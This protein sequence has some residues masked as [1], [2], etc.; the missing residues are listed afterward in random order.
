MKIYAKII[1]LTE[2]LNIVRINLWQIFQISD[3]CKHF[4]LRTVIG[5]K[6]QKVYMICTICVLLFETGNFANV[7]VQKVKNT[8]NTC[9]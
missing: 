9:V 5:S 3:F 8:G 1:K 4:L 2:L 6:K 7:F